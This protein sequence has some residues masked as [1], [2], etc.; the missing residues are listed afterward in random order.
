MSDWKAG[1]LAVCVD[2]ADRLSTWEE[3]CGKLRRGACY[4]ITRVVALGRGLVLNEVRAANPSGFWAD[5]FRKLNDEPD[6][7]EI[8]ARIKAPVREPEHA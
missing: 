3:D 5:R 6:N 1:D 4:R 7:A 8:I 2:A